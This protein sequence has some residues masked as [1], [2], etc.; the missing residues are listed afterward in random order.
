[1]LKRLPA[2]AGVTS[3]VGPWRSGGRLEF[4]SGSIMIHMRQRAN[5]DES[6]GTLN[7]TKLIVEEAVSSPLS[8]PST[9]TSL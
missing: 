4:S 9:L 5:K 7:T 3:G 1:M 8:S 6:S 2:G